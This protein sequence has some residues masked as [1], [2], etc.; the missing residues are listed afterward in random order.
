LSGYDTIISALGRNAILAQIPLL[1]L[2]EASPSIHTFY[3]S[4]FGTDI[5]YRP[6]SIIENPHQPKL[7]VRRYIRENVKK[8]KITYLVDGG[9]EAA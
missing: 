5:E 7:E 4:E 9:A 1:K 2:T 8:L 3:P 6:M